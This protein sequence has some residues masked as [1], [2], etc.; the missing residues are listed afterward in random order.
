[1]CVPARGGLFLAAVLA[2]SCAGAA[3]GTMDFQNNASYSGA[4]DTFM[5][6]QNRNDENF[7]SFWELHVRHREAYDWDESSL[8]YFDI[9]AIPGGQTI[10]GATLRL[11]YYDDDGGSMSSSDTLEVQVWRMRKSWT[12]GTG[13][14][15]PNHTGHNGQGGSDRSGASWSYRFAYPDTTGWYN[16]GARGTDPSQGDRLA[17]YDAGVTITG[18]NYGFYYWSDANVTATVA[19]WYQNPGQ[20]FGWVIDHGASS[21]TNNGVI[22]FSSDYSTS[23]ADYYLRPLLEVTYQPVPEPATMALLALVGATVLARR[24]RGS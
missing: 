20:N 5:I 23:P 18:D 9:S 17:Y 19:A 1:M 15:P 21:D 16:E 11:Y 4:R 6:M 10:T 7:G 8:L 14:D 2:M 13:D 12:V 3:A 22:F 24:R